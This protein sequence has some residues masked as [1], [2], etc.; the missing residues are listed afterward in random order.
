MKERE[1]ESLM[2][3]QEETLHYLNQYRESRDYFKQLSTEMTELSEARKTE[4]GRIVHEHEEMERMRLEGRRAIGT[5]TTIGA[6]Y[7]NKKPGGGDMGSSRGSGSINSQRTG[8]RNQGKPVGGGGRIA[9]GRP[10]AGAMRQGSRAMDG[11][12]QASKQGIAIDTTSSH[13]KA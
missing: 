2:M 12:S 6:N 9:G 10:P 3:Y 5:Q 8:V 7:F 1:C 11:Q 4:I 13:S